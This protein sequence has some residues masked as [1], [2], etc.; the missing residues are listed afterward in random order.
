MKL[1]RKCCLLDYSFYRTNGSDAPK[2]PVESA[3]TSSIQQVT[4]SPKPKQ[5]VSALDQAM[6]ATLAA[7]SAPSPQI[8][9]QRQILCSVK[10]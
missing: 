3:P 5:P 8:G 10:H 7:I 2:A 1:L 9:K 4:T 6:A